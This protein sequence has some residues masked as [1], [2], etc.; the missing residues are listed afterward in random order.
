MRKDGFRRIRLLDAGHASV[1]STITGGQYTPDAMGC[2]LISLDVRRFIPL[3]P[4]FVVIHDPIR[5][6][7]I[8]NDLEA[9][10]H[11]FVAVIRHTIR[12]WGRHTMV[13][14]KPLQ[15]LWCRMDRTDTIAAEVSKFPGCGTYFAFRTFWKTRNNPKSFTNIQSVHSTPHSIYLAPEGLPPA[16][17]ILR[18]RLES[19]PLPMMTALVRLLPRTKTVTCEPTAAD[20]MLE[21]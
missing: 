6:P 16:V 20:A 11:N 7:I 4:V 1:C 5:K 14:R 18:Q 2:Q 10:K 21:T 19:V 3:C 15:R 17:F 9:K 13:R 12:E 8:E